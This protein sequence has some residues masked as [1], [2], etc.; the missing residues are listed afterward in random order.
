[1]SWQ[2]V[3][4]WLVLVG[5]LIVGFLVFVWLTRDMDPLSTDDKE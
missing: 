1:M 5:M 2:E 3:V 4:F